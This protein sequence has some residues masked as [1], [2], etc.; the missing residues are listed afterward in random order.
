MS[1]SGS[2]AFQA[3]LRPAKPLAGL[4][5]LVVEDEFVIALD[6]QASLEEAG[7][8]VIGPALTITAALALAAQADISVATLDLSI[9]RATVLP[10]ARMLAERGIPF[11]FYTGQAAVDPVHQEWPNCRSLSKPAKPEQLIQALADIAYRAT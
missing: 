1:K 3:D 6:L 10:V 7:A 11:V 2:P 8:T 4:C 9:G 5:V